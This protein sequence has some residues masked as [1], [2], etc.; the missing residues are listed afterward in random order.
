M[1][2][3]HRTYCS[4]GEEGLRFW[5]EKVKGRGLGEIKYTG[6]PLSGLVNAISTRCSEKKTSAHV[7]FYI[8]VENV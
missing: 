8:S 5:V 3:F 2:D 6:K 1:M 7:F 4:D